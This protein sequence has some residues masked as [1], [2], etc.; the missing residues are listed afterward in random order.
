MAFTLEV[1]GKGF[2][3][4]GADNKREIDVSPAQA[5][6][7]QEILDRR[8]REQG[9]KN[10]EELLANVKIA[11]PEAGDSQFKIGK[12]YELSDTDTMLMIDGNVQF[13]NPDLIDAYHEGS[14][15]PDFVLV[16]TMQPEG[17]PSAIDAIKAPASTPDGRKDAVK[18]YLGEHSG[19]V[20]ERTNA[21]VALMDSR[22]DFGS[23]ELQAPRL[24]EIMDVLVEPHEGEDARKKIV[25]A[26]K[27]HSWSSTDGKAMDDKGMDDKGMD[28]L[29]SEHARA[30]YGIQ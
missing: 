4:K 23:P 13:A 1:V 19:S 21:A 27:Q 18:T 29:I 9:L 3:L 25:D 14:L 8:A 24:K 15:N 26:L 2:R 10:S 5:K 28:K 17:A 11:V 6:A 16:P 12:Q 22:A 20:E 7:W 30:A